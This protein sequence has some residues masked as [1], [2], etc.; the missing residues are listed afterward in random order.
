MNNTLQLK[1]Q[2]HSYI[3]LFIISVS[4]LQSG[5]KLLNLYTVLIGQKYTVP[6]YKLITVILSFSLRIKNVLYPCM[7]ILHANLIREI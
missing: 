4:K 6:R 1:K 7:H 2:R 5:L 3:Q